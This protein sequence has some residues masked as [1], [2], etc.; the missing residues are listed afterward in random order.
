MSEQ[1]DDVQKQD[2][3]ELREMLANW[4]AFKRRWFGW[5]FPHPSKGD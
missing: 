1:T 4:Q 2:E 5:L 3:A